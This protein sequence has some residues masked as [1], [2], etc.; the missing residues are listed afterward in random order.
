MYERVDAVQLLKI[1]ITPGLTTMQLPNFHS[2]AICLSAEAERTFH[3]L[4]VSFSRT[5]IFMD[6]LFNELSYSVS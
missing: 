1:M 5:I 2:I 6:I 3:M 4:A